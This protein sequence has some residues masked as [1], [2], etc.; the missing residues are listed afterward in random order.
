MFK[1]TIVRTKPTNSDFKWRPYLSIGD[2]DTRVFIRK[3]MLSEEVTYS[4]DG[5][6]ITEV[7]TYHDEQCFLTIQQMMMDHLSPMGEWI[8]FYFLQQGSRILSDVTEEIPD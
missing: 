4:E 2:I 1:H 7:R 5:T 6:S 3:H 8:T